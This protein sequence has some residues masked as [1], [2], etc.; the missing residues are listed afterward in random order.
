MMNMMLNILEV[1]TKMK[2]T[3]NVYNVI[4]RR[5]ALVYADITDELIELGKQLNIETVVYNSLAEEVSL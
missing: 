3:A 1:K 4:R 5:F 2:V